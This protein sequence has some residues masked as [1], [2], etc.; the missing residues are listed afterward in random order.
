[1]HT[2]TGGQGATGGQLL[3]LCWGDTPAAKPPGHHHAHQRQP[4]NPQAPPSHPLL[5]A[6]VLSGSGLAQGG[7]VLQGAGVPSLC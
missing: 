5:T 3:P 2:S 4:F 1:M 7:V 6:L